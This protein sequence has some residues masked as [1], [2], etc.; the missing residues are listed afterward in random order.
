MDGKYQWLPASRLRHAA[1]DAGPG[2]LVGVTWRCFKDGYRD[3]ES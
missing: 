3:D 1:A 2:R